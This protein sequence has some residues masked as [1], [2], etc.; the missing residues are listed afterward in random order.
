[1]QLVILVI[2]INTRNMNIAHNNLLT[3]S[4]HSCLF[5]DNDDPVHRAR[6]LTEWFH[7][8]E[9]WCE[10]QSP[11]VSWSE[12]L[13]EEWCCLPTVEVQSLALSSPRCTEAV[14]VAH[15]VP[16][17]FKAISCCFF[18]S[19]CYLSAMEIED[20]LCSHKCLS[21]LWSHS[22]FFRWIPFRQRWCLLGS[23]E[24]QW[25]SLQTL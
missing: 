2:Q 6:G 14:L 11:E 19:V 22:Q 10:S 12:Y 5:L 20:S 21:S 13:L 7:E 3:D 23:L 24:T 4:Q 1:M 8:Y 18:P 17:P 9:K 16:T 15:G 25:D